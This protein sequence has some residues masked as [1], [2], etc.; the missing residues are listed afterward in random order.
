MKTKQVARFKKVLSLDEFG[1]KQ[2]GKTRGSY[3]T[4]PNNKTNV[5]NRILQ[6]KLI[7]DKWTSLT[8][9]DVK[10]YFITEVVPILKLNKKVG[11]YCE[12]CG[13]LIGK[14]YENKK[15]NWLKTWCLCDG[16]YQYKKNNNLEN[17]PDI[18]DVERFGVIMI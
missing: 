4:L 6:T 12:R 13:I 10:N 18:E 9:Q 1:N 15:P 8:K 11:E 3:N 16:C 14:K 5:G 7:L 2:Y 17:T